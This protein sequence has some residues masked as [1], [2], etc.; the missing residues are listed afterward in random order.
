MRDWKPF[1]QRPR[2][3]EFVAA[4]IVGVA[5]SVANGPCGDREHISIVISA[6]ADCKFHGHKSMVG[7]TLGT[8]WVTVAPGMMVVTISQLNIAPS[9]HSQILRKPWGQKYHRATVCIGT[10]RLHWMVSDYNVPT[11]HP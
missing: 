6:A 4:S 9:C 3:T 7:L 10:A 2:W 5:F 8:E 11:R 1:F